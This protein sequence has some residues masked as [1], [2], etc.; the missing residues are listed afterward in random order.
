MFTDHESMFSNVDVDE[1]S[2]AQYPKW[3]AGLTPSE[4]KRLTE[5]IQSAQAQY[6]S[7]TRMHTYNFV[8]NKHKGLSKPKFTEAWTHLLE[9]GMDDRAS[10]D[11]GTFEACDFRASGSFFQA[12]SKEHT[13]AQRGS[14]PELGSQK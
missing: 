11:E 10:D 5:N 1:S 6:G 7:S 13:Q 12:L 3:I 14:V 4:R 8:R 2:L 9:Q